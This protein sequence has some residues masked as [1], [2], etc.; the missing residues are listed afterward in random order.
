MLKP[1]VLEMNEV[2]AGV[3]T[4]LRRLIGEN[5]ELEFHPHKLAGF[6]KADPSQLE[7]VIVNLV[8]NARD[9]MPAGGK[10]RISTGHVELTEK[11]TADHAFLRPGSY[12][13]LSV[14][15]NGH[16][17]DE[18]TISCIFEPFFTTKESGKGTGLGLAMVYGTVKQSGG[19]VIVNSHLGQ[20]TTFDIYLPRVEASRAGE[21]IEQAP[22]PGGGA[23]TILVVEDQSDLRGLLCTVLQKNGY[24]V[25]E[26]SDGKLAL[27]E[28]AEHSKDIALVITDM[29][30]PQMGGVDLGTQ[31]RQHTQDLKILYISGYTDSLLARQGNIPPG[32]AFL[33]KPF[34]P[35]ILARKVREVLDARPNLESHMRGQT[36]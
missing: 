1:K 19:Y 20:G 17:M 13:S 14:T 21:Q 25:I 33:Q 2:V 30:M 31:L 32:S 6:V 10:L 7:Q 24:S 28:F 23:E 18:K 9:A 29:V 5:I 16:G 3:E 12:I 26:A 8:V 27:G 22:A 35:D 11:A 15:D 4:M 34:T 36:V